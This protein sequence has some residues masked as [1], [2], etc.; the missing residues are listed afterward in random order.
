M[1]KEKIHNISPTQGSKSKLNL[2]GSPSILNFLKC[3]NI[4]LMKIFF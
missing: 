1:R 3:L 2:L 4:L